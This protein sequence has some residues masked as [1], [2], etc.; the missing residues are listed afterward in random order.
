MRR[1]RI[2]AV[3]R[4]GAAAWGRLA[5]VERARTGS[6][7]RGDATARPAEILASGEEPA[8]AV[9]VFR[10]WGAAFRFGSASASVPI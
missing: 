1:E 10:E 6:I 2:S 5:T 4:F 7:M 9:D 8:L 3:T